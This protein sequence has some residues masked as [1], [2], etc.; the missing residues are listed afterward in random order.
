MQRK[1]LQSHS[2]APTITVQATCS[3]S[4]GVPRQGHAKNSH[5]VPALPRTVTHTCRR[6]LEVSCSSAGT[7]TSEL[8]LPRRLA[9]EFL[10]VQQPARH[11]T[12][13]KSALKAFAGSAI[14]AYECGYSEDGFQKQF[15][16][17]LQHLPAG[18]PLHLEAFDM[19]RCRFLLSLI[20]ITIMLAPKRTVMRWSQGSPVEDST[21][22]TWKGFVGMIVRGWFEKRWSWYPIE[23][24]QLE[25]RM[26]S[27]KAVHPAVVSEWAGV[28]FATLESVAPQFPKQ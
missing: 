27:G 6:R 21:L 15:E 16:H 9:E 12:P 26:T 4:V 17:E 10:V 11:N 23:R 1:L 22:A 13:Y 14:L 2:S 20:W 7:S 8:T 24:L 19:D 28:V 3:G 18:T 25:L 5:C